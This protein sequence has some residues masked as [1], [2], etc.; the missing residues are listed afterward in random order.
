MEMPYRGEDA[1]PAPS[2]EEAAATPEGEVPQAME[3]KVSAAEARAEEANSYMLDAEAERDEAVAAKEQA[4]KDRD[5]AVE[6]KE[7]AVKLYDEAE[8]NLKVAETERDEAIR[9]SEAA[10]TE[11]DEATEEK[12]APAEEAIP[13]PAPSVGLTE[14]AAAALVSIGDREMTEGQGTASFSANAVISELL[15][16][17]LIKWT[18]TE[19]VDEKRPGKVGLTKAGIE[20]LAA[21]EG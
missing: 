12:E 18:A 20:F 15:Y 6:E 14:K 11:R 13:P 3:E 2:E 4:E 5:A 19:N 7:E 1:P 21:Q 10:E 16:K 9:A 8:A 17:G